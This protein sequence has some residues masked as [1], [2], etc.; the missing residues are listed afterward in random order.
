MHGRECYRRNSE[1]VNYSFYKNMMLVV[2]LW[3]FGFFSKFS[4]TQ[5]YNQA[6]YSVYNVFFTALP[7]IWFATFDFEYSKETLLSKPRLYYIGLENKY[8]S[9]FASVRYM[10]YAVWYST[11]ML[12]LCFI[13]IDGYAWSGSEG[14]S[15]SL[16]IAG[17][18]VFTMLV[19]SVNMKILIGSTQV[20]FY[21][22][23]FVLGSVAAY[24]CVFYFLSV[25][26]PA[27]NDYMVF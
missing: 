4:G 17:E 11:L 1:A 25:Y 19:I 13:T 6:A 2:P 9:G 16:F 24:I 10:F 3:M 12:F 20:S 22:L 27:A 5:I 8:M 21:S 23:F 18:F 14:K 15:G 7:I 26:S